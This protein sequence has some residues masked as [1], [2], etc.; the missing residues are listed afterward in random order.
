M[1]TY[2]N[3]KHF[4][5]A[6]NTI[7]HSSWPQCDSIRGTRCHYETACLCGTMLGALTGASQRERED[8]TSRKIAKC[9]EGWMEKGRT[10]KP[11]RMAL[12]REGS[13]RSVSAYTSVSMCKSSTLTSTVGKSRLTLMCTG[14]RQQS[15]AHCAYGAS[16]HDETRGHPGGGIARRVSKSR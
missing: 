11:E 9:T 6:S 2:C 3:S 7:T 5:S 10:S 14:A 15:L 8:W 13:W 12:S 1:S 4:T 16:I